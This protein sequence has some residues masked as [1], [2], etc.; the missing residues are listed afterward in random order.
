MQKGRRKYLKVSVLWRRKRNVNPKEEE[1]N[2]AVEAE[3]YPKG[4]TTR[5]MRRESYQ[6]Q[7][8]QRF[9]NPQVT[10]YAFFNCNIGLKLNSEVNYEE[11]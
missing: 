10:L 8:M 9:Q 7:N 4:T 1:I 2:V 6:E 11:S 5:Q 3:I